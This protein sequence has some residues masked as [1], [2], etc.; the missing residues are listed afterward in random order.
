MQLNSDQLYVK[1]F[2]WNCNV[3]DRFIDPDLA[4]DSAR[5]AMRHGTTLCGFF[6]RLFWGTLVSALSVFVWMYPMFTL[7]V[8]PFLLFNIT[9]VAMTVGFAVTVLAATVLLAAA[10]VMT[11]T[12]LRWLATRRR[13]DEAPETEA[14]PSFGQ[15]TWSY[16]KGIKQRVCPRITFKE[17]DNV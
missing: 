16:V 14:P 2:L 11:P 17:I 8:L 9:T 5:R 12:A 7:F 4:G 1:W 6:H 10:V 3:L 15:V 13:L